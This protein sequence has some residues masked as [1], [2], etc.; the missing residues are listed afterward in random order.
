[1]CC[2][3]FM[4]LSFTHILQEDEGRPENK[5]NCL[6]DIDQLIVQFIYFL[7]YLQLKYS[8]N[9]IYLTAI[10][11]QLK[12]SL[13]HVLFNSIAD[14]LVQ[15]KYCY[16]NKYTFNQK[17]FQIL[18]RRLKKKSKHNKNRSVLCICV[19]V[20]KWFHTPFTSALDTYI[21][22]IQYIQQLLLAR[23]TLHMEYTLL[24]HTASRVHTMQGTYTIQEVFYE[25]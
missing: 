20:G 23:C 22:Y 18:F 10:I 5:M 17:L 21:Q 14:H 19:Y 3:T 2:I 15:L 13:M 11:V 9:K 25:T 24:L 1:M 12:Y 8:L 6:I 4:S 16:Q 7:I